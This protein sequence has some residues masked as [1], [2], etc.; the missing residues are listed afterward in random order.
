M[1]KDLIKFMENVEIVN[2]DFSKYEDNE[3]GFYF[4]IGTA[5]LLASCEYIELEETPLKQAIFNE[6]I[7]KLDYNKIIVSRK[8]P[9]SEK[10]KNEKDIATII[11]MDVEVSQIW[12][13]RNQLRLSKSFTTKEEAVNYAKEINNKVLSKLN[14]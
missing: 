14:N 2:K 12:V 6:E 11:D 1:E 3:K 7:E 8:K 9:K 5:Q 4:I 13:V 10:T